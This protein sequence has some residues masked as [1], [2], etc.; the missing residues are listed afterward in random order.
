MPNPFLGMDPYLEGDVWTSV[1]TDLCAQIVRQLSPL[2]RPKYIA[3]TNR[4]FV[5]AVEQPRGRHDSYPDVG[6]VERNGGVLSSTASA[7]ATAAPVLMMDRQRTRLPLLTVEI[8]DVEQRRLVTAIEVLSPTNK[9]GRGRREYATKRRRTLASPSHLVEIDLLRA[10]TRYPVQDALPPVPYFAFVSR[11]ERRPQVEVWPMP[12][13]AP[14]PTIPIPLL[15][16]DADVLLDLQLALTSIYEI[17]G[18][19]ALLDYTQPPPGPLTEQQAAWVE[20]RLRAAG[21]R[22]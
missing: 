1:H 18:Y 12:L 7:T 17:V 20:E 2:I 9:R 11:A 21:R 15:P 8:R 22:G 3:T 6:V 19:D 4:R 14:L 10:G 5:V 16:G 13:E